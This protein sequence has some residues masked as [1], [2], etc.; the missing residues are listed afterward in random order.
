MYLRSVSV[1]SL[2]HD[3]LCTY[4]YRNNRQAATVRT[5]ISDL[6]AAEQNKDLSSCCCFYLCPDLLFSV[7]ISM[8]FH[9]SKRWL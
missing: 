6:V 4:V 3:Y 1:T 7:Q 5:T 9:W 2:L 8:P